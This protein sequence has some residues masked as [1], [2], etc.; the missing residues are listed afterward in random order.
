LLGFFT[1]SHSLQ[2]HHLAPFQACISLRSVNLLKCSKLL[3]IGD[4]TFEL[5]THLQEIM[6]P[7]KVKHIGAGAFS[8]CKE[9]V[10]VEFPSKVS[11]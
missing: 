6:M 2:D 11:E 8:Q 10:K 3:S 5:C 4:F 7:M 9:L 1:T